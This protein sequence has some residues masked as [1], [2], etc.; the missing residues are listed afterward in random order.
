MSAAAKMQQW[1]EGLRSK[2]ADTSEEGEE[3]WEQHQRT[4]L[5]T[6]VMSWEQVDII[7]GPWTN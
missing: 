6:R 4:N 7:W 1:I 5:E 2:M 3:K